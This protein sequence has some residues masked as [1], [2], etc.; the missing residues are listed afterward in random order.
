MNKTEFVQ[1]VVLQTIEPSALR[2]FIE[3]RELRNDPAIDLGKHIEITRYDLRM[4]DMI[5]FA[6]DIYNRIQTKA[7][8]MDWVGKDAKLGIKP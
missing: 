2:D 7:F 3:Y 8:G 1:H 6:E 4:Q 5:S